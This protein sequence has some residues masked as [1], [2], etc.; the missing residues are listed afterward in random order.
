MLANG[1]P[2]RVADKSNIYTPVTLPATDGIVA[3]NGS[4]KV[5]LIYKG[6]ATSIFYGFNVDFVGS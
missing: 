2:I 3:N 1:Q 4:V 6:A 5:A